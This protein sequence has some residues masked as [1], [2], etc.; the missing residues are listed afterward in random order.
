MNIYN[1]LKTFIVKN[2][3]FLLIIIIL[4]ITVGVL[5]GENMDLKYSRLYEV[6]TVPDISLTDSLF[7]YSGSNYNN[8]SIR[9]FVVFDNKN[10]QP[11]ELRQYYIIE[12]SDKLDE[13]LNRIF[14]LEEIIKMNYLPPQSM[15]KVELRQIDWS[16]KGPTLIDDAG[17]KFFIN[18]NSDEVTMEDVTGDETR[19]I[20]SDLEYKDF[21]IEFL[22]K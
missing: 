4:L 13:N 21:M 12:P 8:G 16:Y 17:N 11:R 14:S 9:G 2:K 18:N 7:Y 15:G 3:I 6:D 20:M 22:N 1:K 10:D 5:Y 19:L